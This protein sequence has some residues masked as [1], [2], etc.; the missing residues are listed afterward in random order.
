MAGSAALL[1]ANVLYPAGLRDMLLRLAS[2]HL[3]A[4]LWSEAIH[5]EWIRS[6]LR[7]RPDLAVEKLERTRSMMDAHFPAAIVTDYDALMADIDLPDLGDRHVLAAAIHGGADV[8]VTFN[9][10]DFPAAQLAEHAMAAKHPD[11][12]IGDLFDSNPDTV[13]AA[14]RDHRNALKKP[15]KSSE[16][17]LADLERIGL[18]RSAALLRERM[19]AI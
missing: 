19:D 11:A 3:Y 12:F 6:L 5:E 17:Y 2:R 15:P 7:N 13:L 18:V 1:D 4:P 8:I 10:Q 16:E 9:Q 14:A